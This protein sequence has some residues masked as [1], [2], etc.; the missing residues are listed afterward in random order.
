MRKQLLKIA[1]IFFSIGMLA[2]G[3]Q[4][5]TGYYAD[6]SGYGFQHQSL[7]YLGIS[8]AITILGGMLV[9]SVVK[10]MGRSLW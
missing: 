10:R 2:S 8:L 9:I 6:P 1:L 3:M 5:I 7:A 4:T